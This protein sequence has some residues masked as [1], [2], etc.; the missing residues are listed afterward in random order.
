[1]R[2]FCDIVV[3]G[4]GP[5]GCMAAKHAAKKG[6]N[7]ILIEKKSE[8]GAPLRCAEG[9]SKRD[10]TDL[11]IELDPAWISSS[12]K[13]AVIRSPSGIAI[14]LNERGK[15]PEVGY[16][17]ERHLFDKYLAEE[18]SIAGAK[19][20]L[21]TG[22]TGVLKNE[23][24]KIVGIK[25]RSMGEKIEIY[26]KC[27]IAADGYESQVGRWAGIDTSVNPDNIDTCVQ[28]RMTN[29]AFETSVC[30]FVVGSMAPGGYIWI[31]PKSH[32]VANV[33]I[34]IMASK[35]K[36]KA[37]P[38]YYLDKFIREDSRFKNGQILEMTCGMVSTVPGLEKTTM[39]GLILVGDAA[40]M[41]D[42][43]TGGGIAHAC[44]SGKFAGNV[45]AA[46]LEKMD[47]SKEALEAYEKMWR[48]DMED[49]LYRDWIIKEKFTALSDDK[50]DRVIKRV[51]NLSIK[52]INA[53][54]LLE[55]I[56]ENIP[57]LIAELEGS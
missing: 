40:R 41:I 56:K 48:D 18:A 54:N 33:G 14:Q 12:I 49:K 44:K 26:A 16:I 1:M 42:P 25:A 46:C 9:I 43:I 32:N 39:D 50:L 47:F 4:A 35:C 34:G 19:I 28:Y 10:L 36:H 45:S 13:G 2:Y 51:K 23:N 15:G 37:D 57:D 27:I 22:C 5:G 17:L 8:I 29:V 24:E 7:V 55:V 11:G 21:R 31:F 38:K 53:Q 52:E 6:A 3:V 20:M 30:E